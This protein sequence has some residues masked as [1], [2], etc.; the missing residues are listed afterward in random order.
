MISWWQF[1]WRLDWQFFKRSLEETQE[2]ERLNK[3]KRLPT[4]I[5]I[6]DI[7]NTSVERERCTRV[8]DCMIKNKYA[9]FYMHEPVTGCV[10]GC[11]EM[12]M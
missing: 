3:N 5:R 8:L 12:Q 9:C 1:G 10:Q 7:M 2:N 4:E 11:S 6:G